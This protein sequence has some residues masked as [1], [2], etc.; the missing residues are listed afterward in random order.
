MSASTYKMGGEITQ[1]TLDLI[2]TKINK[3]NAYND[4]HK[5]SNT[6]KP[7]GDCSVLL[8]EREN[9]TKYTKT[10]DSGSVFK[11]KMDVFFG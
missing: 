6:D 1:E 3:I 5:Y 8:Q 9:A 4:S 2:N 11:K 10:G 7:N